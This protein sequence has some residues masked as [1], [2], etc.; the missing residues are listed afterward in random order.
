MIYF[1]FFDLRSRCEDQ[2]PAIFALTVTLTLQY[3]NYTFKNLID[4]RMKCAGLTD[5][6][7]ILFRKKLLKKHVNGTISGLYRTAKPQSYINN[8][9]FLSMYY[10]ISDKVQYIK[11][12]SYR[13]INDKNNY[14]PTDYIENLCKIQNNNLLTITPTKIYFNY[15]GTN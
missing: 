7:A 6:P 3:N 15:E 10:P 8:P 9:A 12:L 14:I 1:D 5:V 13:A 2:I 4:F 11:L